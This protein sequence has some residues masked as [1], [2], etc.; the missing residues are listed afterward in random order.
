MA[1]LICLFYTK[2]TL[3][4]RLHGAML[5]CSTRRHPGWN[6]LTRS[7]LLF[8]HILVCLNETRS[9]ALMLR[10]CACDEILVCLVSCGKSAM[11]RPTPAAMSCSSRRQRSTCLVGSLEACLGNTLASLLIHAMEFKLFKNHDILK[12]LANIDSLL[13]LLNGKSMLHAV[14]VHAT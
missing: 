14:M 7:S 6:V 4:V 1:C 13:C 5:P 8:L 9:F 11:V 10:P 12:C 2:G 3:G